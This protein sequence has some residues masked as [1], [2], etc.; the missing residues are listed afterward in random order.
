MTAILIIDDDILDQKSMA[1]VAMKLADKVTLVGTG[2]E[3][4]LE[5]DQNQ[6]DC[7][8]LD[9]MLPD[10]TG[11]ELLGQIKERG[12]ASGIIAITSQ[13]D[14]VLAS[15]F[16]R[17]GCS[18]YIPKDKIDELLESITKTAINETQSKRSQVSEMR[19]MREAIEKK[20]EV[21]DERDKDTID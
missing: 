17:G 18:Y 19:K 9:H 15:D 6:Y 14:E 3:A 12:I 2:D 5:L 4:M 16:M 13:G 1:K 8:Y 11:I 10:C 7:I 21:I 20:I